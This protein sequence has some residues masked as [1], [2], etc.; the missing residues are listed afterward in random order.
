M[1]AGNTRDKKQILNS[2]CHCLQHTIRYENLTH[3][4]RYKMIADRWTQAV[5]SAV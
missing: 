5:L 2:V 3:I 1:V 4:S